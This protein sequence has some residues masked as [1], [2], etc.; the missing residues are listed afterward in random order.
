MH[1]SHEVCCFL[2]PL[3]D[4]KYGVISIQ[5]TIRATFDYECEPVRWSGCYLAVFTFTYARQSYCTLVNPNFTTQAEATLEMDQVL[6]NFCV[7]KGPTPITLELN[8]Y[9]ASLEQSLIREGIYNELGK[10]KPNKRTRHHNRNNTF[11]SN[12]SPGIYW[13]SK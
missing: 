10:W 13:C 3:F 6:D 5:K 11:D 12:L 8:V 7:R 4:I 9:E 1:T 2:S